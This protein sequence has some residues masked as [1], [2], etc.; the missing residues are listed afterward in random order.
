[1]C[2]TLAVEIGQRGLNFGQQPSNTHGV[3]LTLEIG[4]VPGLLHRC[5][6]VSARDPC[7]RI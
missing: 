3:S 4:Q 5:E 7:V 1:V 6:P 2:D